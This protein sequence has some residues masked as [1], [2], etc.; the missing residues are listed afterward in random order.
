MLNVEMWSHVGDND[1]KLHS[2]QTGLK[3]KHKIID[4]TDLISNERHIKLKKIQ[5]N[6]YFV[7]GFPG[8]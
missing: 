5:K 1:A 2:L 6:E 4:L 8:I 7:I 3:L